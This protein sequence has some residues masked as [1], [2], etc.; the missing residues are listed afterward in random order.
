MLTSKGKL[1]ARFTTKLGLATTAFS[2]AAV[3]LAGA[4]VATPQS[5]SVPASSALEAQVQH[6]RNSKEGSD[7]S[8][9]ERLECLLEGTLDGFACGW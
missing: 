9:E 1:S 3:T 8:P 5:G 7:Y 6:L 4:A 2:I